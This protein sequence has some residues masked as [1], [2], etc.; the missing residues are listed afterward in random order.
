M[1]LRLSTPAARAT[2]VLFALGLCLSLSYL[3]IRNARA[4]HQ[5]GRETSEGYERATQLEPGDARNWYLLGHY[6][7][8]NVEQPDL[9]RAVRAYQSSLSFDPHS[10]NTWLDLGTAF[11]FEGHITEARKSFLEAKRVYPLSAEVS[12]RY[13]NFLLRQ[14]ELENAFAEIRL[15]VAAD[16]KHGGEAF[17]RCWHAD[18]DLD[19]ILDHVLPAR[20]EVYLAVIFDLATENQT[21]PALKV[22][23]RL[24]VL[25]PKL[26]LRQVFP[27]VNLLILGSRMEMAN[28]VWEEAVQFSDVSTRPDPSGSVVWDGGFE[29]GA[30]GGGFAWEYPASFNSVQIRLDTR[31]K[32]SGRQSLRLQFYGKRNL[33]FENACV[34][35]PVRPSTAYRFSGWVRTRGLTTGEGLRFSLRSVDVPGARVFLTPEIH[36][37]E[38]WTLVEASW[39]SEKVSHGVQICI[40]RNASGKLENEIRGTAWVD[41]VSLVPENPGVQRP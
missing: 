11:E 15:A 20:P 36:G 37:S 7:Q 14:G 30:V 4:A 8:Y 23:S 38:P 1:I 21:E 40:R 16:P 28:R 13:G 35:A 27:L 6:W 3:S 31:E 17:S 26:Q 39:T 5:V 12:W 2:I 24:A 32:H 10:A 9:P 29:T 33:D 18:P 25:H 41:D 34:I 19:L 22:W